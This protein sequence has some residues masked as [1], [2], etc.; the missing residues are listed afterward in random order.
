[1]IFRL[2]ANDFVILSHERIEIQEHCLEQLPYLSQNSL[3]SSNFQL[4]IQKDTIFT[5]E[6]LEE[7]M[8]AYRQKRR[9][10]AQQ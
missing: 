6:S 1:M 8:R 9:E 7:Q 3:S 4:D 5:L 2:H 10:D